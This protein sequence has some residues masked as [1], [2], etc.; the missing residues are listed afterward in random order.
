MAKKSKHKSKSPDGGPATR[1]DQKQAGDT[2]VHQAGQ[3]GAD[4]K[5]NL[6]PIPNKVY[7]K[8]TGQ[9]ADRTG[10]AAGMGEVQGAQGGGPVRRPRCGRKRRHNQENNRIPQSARLP[11]R[12]A[13]NTHRTRKDTMVLPALCAPPASRRRNRPVRPLLVQQGRRGTRHGLLYRGGIRRVHARMPGVRTHARALRYPAHQ[14]LV[15]RQRCRTGT[16]L[17]EQDKNPNQT[18]ETQPNGPGIP[19][20]MDRILKSKG[21]HVRPYR[22]Q[23]GTMVR[24]GG[25]RQ[26]TRKTKLH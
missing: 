14:I 12:R 15:L 1:P 5:S 4:I 17:P 26:K 24:R 10:Q 3:M 21:H 8:E 11:R 19:A 20:K 6:S 2:A 23:T 22:H 7:E 16:P 18:L 25:R 13:R 9:T